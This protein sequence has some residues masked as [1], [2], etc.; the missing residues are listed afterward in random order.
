MKNFNF[1]RITA[2]LFASI[3]VALATAAPA[4]AQAPT[5]AGSNVVTGAT[6]TMDISNIRYVDFTPGA[7]TIT[8]ERGVVH[9][10]Q[11]VNNTAVTGSEAYKKFI[12]VSANV[13]INPSA[14]YSIK[15]VNS[16]TVIDW[17]ITGAETIND[18]C[19]KQSKTQVYSRR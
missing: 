11:F 10:V 14:A 9:Q 12:P 2:A 1:S 17:R 19:A 5:Y 4:Q 16:A 18:G 13:A 7:Q 6:S 15:C 8:D 3:A